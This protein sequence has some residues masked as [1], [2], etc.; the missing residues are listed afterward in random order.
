MD[1]TMKMEAEL[2]ANGAAIA[3]KRALP[4][5]REDFLL[6]AKW[7]AERAIL[8]VETASS[9]LLAGKDKDDADMGVCRGYL[10]GRDR[11]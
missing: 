10:D 11:E 2:E 6:A 9:L 7:L 5:T 8:V 1:T 4:R 3:A